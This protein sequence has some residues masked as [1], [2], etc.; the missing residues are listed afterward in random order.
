MIYSDYI[1]DKFS[2]FFEVYENGP[3]SDK[4]LVQFYHVPNTTTDK[5]PQLSHILLGRDNVNG[6]LKSPMYDYFERIVFDFLDSKN[7]PHGEVTRACLNLQYAQKL[8]RTDPH[9]DSHEDH[10]VVLIYLS[11]STGDTIVYD[12][13]SDISKPGVLPYGSQLKVKDY[14]TPEKGKIV[15]FDGKHYHAN[16]FPDVGELRL[17]CVFNVLF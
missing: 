4:G 10:Y 9:I 15:C 8:P 2:E 14:I 7:L 6:E 12:E 3:I 16:H 17:V 1:I 5:F 11:D 13:T